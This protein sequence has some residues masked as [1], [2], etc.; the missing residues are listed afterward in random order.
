[1]NLV[2]SND[3][4]TRLREKFIPP[5]SEF[6]QDLCVCWFI[7]RK[8]VP[9]KTKNGKNYWI[10][11]VMTPTTRLRRLDAGASSPKKIRF[12]LTD[13]IWLS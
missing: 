4:I 12:L 2:I 5:I 10:V 13:H 1:M 6:D 9:K 11:E 7:P 3:T 8:I